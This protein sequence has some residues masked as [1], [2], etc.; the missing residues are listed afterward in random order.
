[1]TTPRHL[2]V[3][4]VCGGV[5]DHPHHVEHYDPPR[6]DLVPGQDFLDR[7]GEV[8]AGAMTE[9]LNP[10]TRS[11]HMDCC[12]EAGCATCNATEATHGGAKRGADL[13]AHIDSGAVNHLG[14]AALQA[15]VG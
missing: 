1:M 3:C 7:L 2:R 9:L 15:E 5:D 12:A 11:R 8:P 13:I 6:P 10:A 14:L 4:D